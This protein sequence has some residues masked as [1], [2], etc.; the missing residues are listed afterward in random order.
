MKKR[1]NPDITQHAKGRA[2]HSSI[3]SKIIAATISVLM[4]AKITIQTRLMMVV[5]GGPYD[6]LEIGYGKDMVLYG[7]QWDRGYKYNAA[8]D[9]DL[10]KFEGAHSEQYIEGIAEHHKTNSIVT[11]GTDGALAVWSLKTNKSYVRLPDIAGKNTTLTDMIITPNDI[12][13]V[14]VFKPTNNLLYLR[15]QDIGNMGF[16][17]MDGGHKGNITRIKNIQGVPMFISL[18]GA[19]IVGSTSLVTRIIRWEAVFPPRKIAV[20]EEKGV[21]D[22][23]ASWIGNRLFLANI[24]HSLLSVDLKANKKVKRVAKA[25]TDRVTG[26][27]YI[28]YVNFVISGGGFKVKIWNQN[29]ELMETLYDSKTTISGRLIYKEK[30]KIIGAVNLGGIIFWRHCDIPNCH[31]CF[32]SKICFKCEKGYFNNK[33]GE[34]ILGGTKTMPIKWHIKNKNIDRTK[35]R[36]QFDNVDRYEY[37]QIKNHVDPKKHV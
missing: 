28:P 17:M 30:D 29:L 7:D 18:S 24:D 23:E 25:H 15:Y 20:Y 16:L 13:V 3:V 34:C 10:N 37:L 27:A 22:C 8:I 31:V 21:I 36:I 14:G 12:V 9:K 1:T 33:K 19:G 4:F 11:I 32:N 6:C 35:F 2:L 26:L 5:E